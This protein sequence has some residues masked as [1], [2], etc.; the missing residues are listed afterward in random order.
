[1]SNIA[2]M[3]KD[4]EFLEDLGDIIEVFKSSA[5]IQFAGASKRR[6]Y[7][8]DFGGYVSDA[9]HML[10]AQ[11]GKGPVFDGG[12]TQPGCLIAV[13]TDEGF[14]GELNTAVINKAI[15]AVREAHMQV[16]VVGE[17]GG[18]HLDDVSLPYSAFPGVDTTAVFPLAESIADT[19]CEQYFSGA[20]FVRVIHPHFVSV[21]A[22]RTEDVQ[23]LP[24]TPDDQERISRFAPR[25][26]SL[27]PNGTHVAVSL[28][29]LWVAYRLADI[30]FDSKLAELSARIM[31]LEGSSQELGT[32]QTG[33]RRKFF[34]ELHGLNDKSIRE[35]SAAKM[36]VRR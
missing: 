23:L 27:E 28:A 12:G 36:L 17:R 25:Y 10:A 35:I 21:G 20:A 8:A 11:G 6:G 29:R 31:H 1:M 34:K 5:V 16:S 24:F 9:M 26:A 32:M 14:L 22:Q 3:K 13:T 4:S 33:L 7:L 19:V 18:H 2:E 30:L 15:D